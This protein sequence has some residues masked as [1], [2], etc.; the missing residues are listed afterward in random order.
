MQV[1]RISILL[2]LFPLPDKILN[3]LI[4]L[5][6]STLTIIYHL[7]LEACELE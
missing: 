2:P 3:I 1:F 7:F 6:L 4:H 5:F